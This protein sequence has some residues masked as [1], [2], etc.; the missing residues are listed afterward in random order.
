MAVFSKL[1]ITR[2]GQALLAKI[3]S[4]VKNV[5]FTSV[6][7]S[8]AEYTVEELENLIALSEIKQTSLISEKVRASDITVKIEAAFNNFELASGYYMRTLGLY[9][10]DPDDG[11][12]LYGVAIETSG[13]CYVPPYNGITVSG[14][15]IQLVITVGNAENVSLEVN[16]GAIATIKQVNNLAEIIN[17]HV[18]ASICTSKGVHDLRYYESKLQIYDPESQTWSN[19]GA[20][21]SDTVIAKV[22]C[23]GNGTEHKGGIFIGDFPTSYGDAADTMLN[24]S[25]VIEIKRNPNQ[26][27]NVSGQGD[28]ISGAGNVIQ[29]SRTLVLGNGNKFNSNETTLTITDPNTGEVK[30]VSLGTNGNTVIAGDSNTLDTQCSV[31]SGASNTLKAINSFVTGLYNIVNGNSVTHGIICG[32]GYNVIGDK[33]GANASYSIISG[34]ENNVNGSSSIV[35]GSNNTQYGQGSSDVVAGCDNVI[36]GVAGAVFGRKNTNYV[37]G[38][39]TSDVTFMAGIGNQAVTETN[40]GAEFATVFG[41]GNIA[42]AINFV[43]GMFCKTPNPTGDPRYTGAKRGDLFVVGNGTGTRDDD[44]NVTATSRSNAFRIACDGNVYGTKSYTASGAD[45]A[46][47]FEWADGNPDN[48][49]RRGLFVTLDGEKIRPANAND[50]YILGVVSATPSVVADAQTDDWG[51]KWKTDIFGERL[52]DKNGAWILNEN[53]REE[54]NESY[55]SRLDRKEWAAVGLVGKLIVV[56]DGT[57]EVNGYCVPANGGKATKSET[58]YRVLSRVDENHIK[59]LIK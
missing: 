29:S 32:G 14:T 2:K 8:N 21:D 37:S 40:S 49:D 39:F 43:C 35:A 46:E 59:V 42:K 20:G 36:N 24:N 10:D 55:V 13:N 33:V 18:P 54:E 12:I 23:A 41:F 51:K 53:F 25:I 26:S 44:Y 27:A 52:L 38:G 3:L 57:C 30:T 31:V 11:E 6:S 19:A 34:Y 4:G 15:Y 28:I 17:A 1:V 56:D 58:G 9:A 45:Y 50:D 47:M 48:E 16:P 5:N 7:T 22:I